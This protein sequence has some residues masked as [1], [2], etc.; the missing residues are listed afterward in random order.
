MKSDTCPRQ[1]SLFFISAGKI[2][3]HRRESVYSLEIFGS[4][5]GTDI[6]SVLSTLIKTP[7][8][9]KKSSATIFCSKD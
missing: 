4:K 2:T 9:W 8:I 7:W 6:L 1:V 5:N 3:M